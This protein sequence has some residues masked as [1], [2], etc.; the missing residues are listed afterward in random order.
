MSTTGPWSVKGID[1]KAREIAKDLARRSGMTLGEWLNRMIIEG[2]DEAPSADPADFDRSWLDA[3]RTRS[4]AASF[5]ATESLRARLTR[6]IAQEPPPTARD[7]G[8][9]HNSEAG[10]LQRIAKALAALSERIEQTEHRSTLS[11]SGIDQQVMGVLGRVE[12]AERD[13]TAAAARFDMALEEV[14]VRQGKLAERLRRFDGD[15]GARMEAIKALEG[16]ITKIAGQIYEGESQARTQTA[17]LREDV[18][19]LAR[20]VDR[21]DQTADAYVERRL[22]AVAADLIKRIEAVKTETEAR[23]RDGGDSKLDRLEGALRDVAAKVGDSEKRSAEAIDRMGRDVLRVTQSMATRVQAVE[24]RS[25]AASAQMGSE[26]AR[27]A[28]AMEGRMRRADTAQAASL[29]KLGG[30]IA[31]IAEKLADRIA[32]SER[33]SASAMTHMGD[34]LS[35]VTQR[36]NQRDDQASAELAERIRA[37]EE[38]TGKLLAETRDNIDR[39]LGDALRAPA[40]SNLAIPPAPAAPPATPAPTAEVR[41]PLAPPSAADHFDAPPPAYDDPFA[42][43]PAT[44]LDAFADFPP[45]QPFHTDDAF[46]APPEPAR[47]EVLSARSNHDLIASARAAARAA[48]ESR[49]RRG[50]GSDPFANSPAAFDPA[51]FGGPDFGSADFGAAEFTAPEIEAAAGRARAGALGFGFPLPR[52]KKKKDGSTLKTLLMASAV[53]AALSIT[54]V[55]AVGVVALDGKAPAKRDPHAPSAAPDPRAALAA[56]DRAALDNAV[57]LADAADSDRLAAAVSEEPAPVATITPH[58]APAP[59]KTASVTPPQAAPAPV[60]APAPAAPAPAPASAA[61]TLYAAAVRSIEAGDAS[62]IETLK[63]AANLGHAPAEFYLAKLYE[64]GASGLK[65]DAAEARRWTERAAQAGDAK[66]MHNLA[67]YWFEGAGGVK[68][69]AQAADWFKRAAERG[70]A[71]SQYNLARL[72]EQGFGVPKNAA[73]AYKWYLIAAE[74]GDQEAKTG[75]ESVKRQLSPEGQAG[76][77]RAASSFRAQILASQ[78]RTAAAQ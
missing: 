18:A 13:Q 51:E 3:P 41:P 23:L 21:A 50:P 47:D 55:G 2:E 26:M 45:E 28:E 43:P 40:L 60:A 48:S 49:G 29:E 53:G 72:Y 8:F 70:V 61:R 19:A 30:E 73:E 11:I 69:A 65:K 75:A 57:D 52:K 42:A 12:N 20:R 15:E 67:L 46:A 71:D 44:R 35:G 33:R 39:R 74:A 27:I 5:S 36:L 76:A 56:L 10:E 22:K 78:L 63:K 31:R 34:Q 17:Q 32:A 66:A 16:A 77:Q 25:A 14:R 9:G 1:P 64:S 38:R 4:Q 24:S 54:A 59:L 62:G 37:S 7:L 68:D 58:A 6:E